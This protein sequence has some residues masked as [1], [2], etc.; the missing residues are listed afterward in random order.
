LKGRKKEYWKEG[1]LE[2]RKVHL[3]RQGR[4]EGRKEGRG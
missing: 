2:G 3:V 1:I 4:K